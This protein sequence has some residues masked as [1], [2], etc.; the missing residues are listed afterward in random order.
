MYDLL[1]AYKLTIA[2]G[3]I[4][5]VLIASMFTGHSDVPFPSSNSHIDLWIIGGILVLL[6]FIAPVLISTFSKK[7]LSISYMG[8]LER[9]EE[10]I[11]TFVSQTG[12]TME[13]ANQRY[14]EMLGVLKPGEGLPDY[15]QFIF[16][17]RILFAYLKRFG[18]LKPRAS[19][20]F[21][22]TP[23]DAVVPLPDSEKES[24]RNFCKIQYGEASARSNPAQMPANT[25]QTVVQ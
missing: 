23:A 19:S 25:Q 6:F 2:C 20:G 5:A 3:V 21:K 17:C 1:K 24:F 18:D 14:A 12:D 8:G 15:F 16:T 10:G 4:A 7:R 9:F 22:F 11:T 13:I